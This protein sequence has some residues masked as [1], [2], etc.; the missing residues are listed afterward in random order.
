MTLVDAFAGKVDDLPTRVR[1]AW[2]DENLYVNFVCHDPKADFLVTRNGKEH[3][4]KVWNDDDVEVFIGYPGDTT[5]Y[6]QFLANTAGVKTELS[7][8]WMRHEYD[9]DP[10]SPNFAWNGQ[11]TVEVDTSQAPK[12][13]RANVTIPFE[14]LQFSP[15]PGDSWR[16]N[17]GR[18]RPK[19]R[20]DEGETA[21]SWN[22]TFGQFGTTGRFGFLTF[23]EQWLDIRGSKRM[24]GVCAE[25]Q[26]ASSLL[27]PQGGLRPHPKCVGMWGRECVSFLC[28]PHTHILT[29]SHTARSHSTPCAQYLRKTYRTY[30]FRL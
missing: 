26:Q 25:C 12:V 29:H 27:L 9:P 4:G 10:L 30:G 5:K 8:G 21:L 16:V 13:W 20:P 14:T 15:D 3:D 17:F 23:A 22:P 18:F 7:R 1:A 6:Y 28:Y 24:H 11:W 19:K 2:D